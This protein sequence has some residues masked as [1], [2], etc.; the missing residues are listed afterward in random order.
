MLIQT[1][2]P[3]LHH[4]PSILPTTSHFSKSVSFSLHPHLSSSTKSLKKLNFKLSNKNPLLKTS[5]QAL[6]CSVSSVSEL[7]QTKVLVKPSPAEICRTIM[8]LSSSGTLSTVN[9]KG[10]PRGIGVQFAV[11]AEGTPILCINASNSQFLNQNRSSLLVQLEQRGSRT[12]Q[13]M[14]EGELNK[15]EDEVVLK[16]LNSI[17]ERRFENEANEGLIYTMSVEGVVQI[18]DSKEECV[19]SSEYKSAIPDPLR[20]FAENIVNEVNMNQMED[21]E[22]ICKI[23]LDTGFQV[24]D[25]N[26]IWIDRLGFDVH[27]RSPQNEIFEAR[28]PFPKEV[29]DWK[30]VKS[31]FNCMSQHAW[32]VDKGYVQSD[33]EKSKHNFWNLLI[34][35]LIYDKL[36]EGHGNAI[37]SA[38]RACE[39]VG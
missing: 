9:H 38:N 24:T 16:K 25:A 13:C 37:T 35:A 31:S 23:Y 15:P 6:K 36:E 29:S 30:G 1:Q 33:F 17:W 20:D 39:A 7:T 11:D 3:T 21:F 8:E 34:N 28:I 12:I 5:F 26:L 27:I 18:Q 32:E 19:T 14:V 2:S 10:Q 22:R 4:L